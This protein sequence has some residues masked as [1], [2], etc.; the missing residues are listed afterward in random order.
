MDTE[1]GLLATVPALSRACTVKLNAPAALGAPP[2][3]PLEEFKASPFG[4]CPPVTDHT[5]GGD[6]PVEFFYTDDHYRSFRG[7][8]VRPAQVRQ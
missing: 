5:S 2:M 6:P 3:T 7:F 1:I 8:R 4:S